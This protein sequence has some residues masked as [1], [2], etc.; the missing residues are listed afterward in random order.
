MLRKTQSHGKI[1]EA[2]T[3]AKCWMNGIPAYNTAGLRANFAGSDLI[4]DT[5]APTRK[6]LVQVKTGYSPVQDQVYLTQCA[7]ECDLTEEKFVADFVVFV[8][9][10]RKAAIAHQHEGSLGFEHLTFYIVPRE[11]ANRVYRNAVTREYN[12]PLSTGGQR[13]LSNMAVNVPLDELAPYKDAWALMRGRVNNLAAH[14]VPVGRRA[15]AAPLNSG[16]LG[17]EG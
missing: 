13:K 14:C 1:G 2:A 7:G 8:N 11:A 3:T 4:I 6:L 17:P 5:D 12:R 9:L 15:S 10:D 16:T